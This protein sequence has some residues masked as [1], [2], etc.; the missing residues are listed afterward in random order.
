MRK[1]HTRHGSLFRRLAIPIVFVQLVVS[2]GTVWL[3]VSF[4]AS[5][6]RST[7]FLSATIALAVVLASTLLIIHVVSRR[8]GQRVRRLATGAERLAQG[9]LQCRFDQNL[10]GVLQE[11]AESLNRVAEIQ[12]ERIRQLG[13]QQSEMQGILHAMRTGVIAMAADGRI[14]SMNPAAMEMFSLGNTE[15]RGRSL[16]D[17]DVDAPLIQFAKQVMAS[18]G[19]GQ[20]ELPLD[21]QHVV[22]RSEAIYDGQGAYVG[23][24]L[25]LDDVTRLRQLEQVR[26]DFAANVSH[27]LRTPITSIHGYAELLSEAA[28]EAERARYAAIVLKNTARLSSIL[29]D[30]LS[31]ARLEDPSQS[32][33][34]EREAIQIHELLDGVVRACSAEAER[35]HVTLKVTCHNQIEC[36]GSRQLL[37]QAVGNLVVN[38]IRYGPD[39]S[40]VVL[41]AETTA[42]GEIQISVVDRG[43][44]IEP[45]QRDRIF[46]RFYRVDQGRS[47]E[48]GGTG[49]GLAIVK[50]I[51]MAHGGRVVVDS[52]VGQG[53]V[54]R[55]LLPHSGPAAESEHDLS[56]AALVS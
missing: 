35:D 20:S 56:A 51:A 6:N 31:L 37:E 48:V 53:S 26:V 16:A 24:V 55:M 44:G 42:E 7:V 21:A 27:E 5:P 28:D 36:H 54:F 39:D 49:L 3:F 11:L 25:V 15:V 12:G 1:H 38:A 34:P 2:I 32:Q 23:I 50:H 47:R 18:G 30:L 52:E 10:P 46:E 45:H 13:L 40:T 43:P 17:I 19:H 29:D 33:L 8:I 9:D 41:A 4:V 14:I 22:V